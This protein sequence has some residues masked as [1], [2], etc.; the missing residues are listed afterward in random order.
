MVMNGTVVSLLSW[1]EEEIRNQ[2]LTVK[3]YQWKKVVRF[4]GICQ[5]PWKKLRHWWDKGDRGGEVG[6]PAKDTSTLKLTC[7][8]RNDHRR[9]KVHTRPLNHVKSLKTNNSL[10]MLY[11]LQDVARIT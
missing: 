1:E 5:N 10:D 2:N 7:D 3:T 8:R 11:I 9:S 6:V 4:R